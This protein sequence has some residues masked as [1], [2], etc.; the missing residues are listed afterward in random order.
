MRRLWYF[1]RDV[2]WSAVIAVALGLG[3]VALAVLGYGDIG[4]TVVGTG[5][6][7]SVVS[8]RA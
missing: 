6:A 8:T 7:L 1:L 4:L 2:A 5:I 3:G